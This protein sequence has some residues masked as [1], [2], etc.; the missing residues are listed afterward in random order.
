MSEFVTATPSIAGFTSGHD[1]Y[2]NPG[3]NGKDQQF[4]VSIDHSHQTRELL[5]VIR[6]NEKETHY[7]FKEVAE[8]FCDVKRE[9]ADVKAAILAV[10]A[11]RIKDDLIRCQNELLAARI[12]GITPP[13]IT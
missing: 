9:I 6:H 7:G 1:Q 10:E 4:A 5:S 11:T 13:V 3:I 8:K 12:A 2:C